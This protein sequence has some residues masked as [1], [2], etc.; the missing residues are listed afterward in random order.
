MKHIFFI[1]TRLWR[2][3][4]IYF[5]K[6]FDAVNDTLTASLLK[7]CSWDTRIVEIGAGDGEF[8]F[9]MHGGIFPLW[10]DR[11][12]QVDTTKKDI[13]S[14]FAGGVLKKEDICV[15]KYPEYLCSI[16]ERDFHAKKIKEIGFAEQIICSNYEFLP[17]SDKSVEKIFYYI[18]HGLKDHDK[19]IKEAARILKSK[20]K[21][22]ILLYDT[23]FK[24]AFLCHKFS[25]YIRNRIFSDYFK[26]LIMED[27]KK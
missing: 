24:K 23:A 11:F 4:N 10:Y 5:L 7:K 12:L 21:I 13:F 8:S 6:P 2:Y 22:L 1:L 3:L 26:N 19:A 25:Q 20:G 9:I 27:M 17:L 18:P 15:P 16:D 14:A